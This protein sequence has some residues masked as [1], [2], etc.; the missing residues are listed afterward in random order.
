MSLRK[1][2]NQDALIHRLAEGNLTLKQ[3]ARE[4]GLSESYLCEIRQGKKRADLK[5][6]IESLGRLIERESARAAVPRL[7]AL[8]AEHGK[9]GLHGRGEN[10]RLCREFILERNLPHANGEVRYGYKVLA[11]RGVHRGRRTGPAASA[12]GQEVRRV[13]VADGPHHHG[14]ALPQCHPESQ[15]A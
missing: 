6:R 8:L 13:R 7:E 4:C 15:R 11:N 3:V 1:A 9:Q 12:P 5:P 2:Y 14:Q 10:A